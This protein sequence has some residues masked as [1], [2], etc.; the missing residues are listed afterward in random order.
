MN[1]REN[2]PSWPLPPDYPQLTQDGQRQARIAVCQDCTS[3]TAYIAGHMYFRHQ[4]LAPQGETFYGEGGLQ[5]PAEGHGRMLSDFYLYPLC[6]EAYGRGFGKSTLFGKEVPLRETVCFPN[7]EV[8]VCSSSDKRVAAS[9]EP[10]MIQLEE[11]GRIIDDFGALVPKKGA[12]RIF[13]KHHMRLLNGSLLEQLTIGSRQRGTRTSRYILDDPEYDPDSKQQERYTELREKLQYFIERQVLYMLRPGHIKFFWIG[14]MI[15]AWSYLYHVCFS[16][17]PKFK[18]WTRRIQSGAVLDKVTGE[19]KRS[20]WEARFSLKHLKFMRSVSEDAFLTEIMNCPVKEKARLLKIDATANE[21]TVTELPPNLDTRNAAHLPHP[22]A[23]MTYHYFTGYDDAGRRRWQIDHV[24]QKEHFDKMLKIATFDY[25]ENVTSK[26][27][28][29]C[30]YIHGIDARNTRWTLDLWAGRMPDELFWD[31]M[32]RFCA[33]WRVEVIAP[34]SIARQKFLVD[35]I[36]RRTYEHNYEALLPGDWNPAII[37][38]VYPQGKE[39]INKGYRIKDAFEYPLPRG[40]V[41]LPASYKHKWPFNELYKQF[42]FFTLDLSELRYD[43]II[44]AGAMIQFVP[45]GKGTAAP[46]KGVNPVQDIV[47]MIKQGGSYVEGQETLVGMPL[48][49]VREEYIGQLILQQEAREQSELQE[50]SNVWEEAV[51]IG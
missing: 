15:G 35:I 4:Y 14:T 49:E 21:Y 47:T 9:A 17:D 7:R 50:D 20:T 6:V 39:N 2:N 51:V 10:I 48:Q 16:K 31:F 43:D 12:K 19:L 8:V 42:Q 5:A 3:A 28:M 30:I 25:A 18:P 26:S 29:K 27:D 11:N 32:A 34:E 45:H 37:P 24:N 41:K 38:V 40:A 44:D 23:V 36:T 33:A 1:P 46:T 22:D 13:N